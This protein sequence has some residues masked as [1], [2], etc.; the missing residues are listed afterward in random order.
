MYE[1]VVA[2]RAEPSSSTTPDTGLSVRLADAVTLPAAASEEFN[3]DAASRYLDVNSSEAKFS[4]EDKDAFSMSTYACA[5]SPGVM[6]KPSVSFVTYADP[7]VTAGVV[8][9]VPPSIRAQP[10]S[11]YSLRA[12][13]CTSISMTGNC[14]VS[15]WRIFTMA[16][17]HCDEFVTAI[18]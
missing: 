12:S 1:N 6:T 10:T 17:G 7:F 2:T 18:V 8:S 14:D 13:F 11:E 3:D 4:F 15:A 5:A 9:E 16:R